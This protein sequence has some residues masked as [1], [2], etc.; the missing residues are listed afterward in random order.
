MLEK[1]RVEKDNN[2]KFHTFTVDAALLRELGERLV[3]KPYVALAELVK[4]S[5]DAD[6]TEVTVTFERDSITVSDNGTGMS[7]PEFIAYWLR[8]GTTHKQNQKLTKR[9]RQVTGSKGV[10]RLSV[11]F[12]GDELEI[13]S[14]GIAETSAFQASVNW[15][16]AREANDLVK[17][18]AYVSTTP[19][20]KK[21]DH[22]YEH[23][24]SVK[25]IGL[26]HQWLVEDLT[27]LAGELWFLKPPTE[28]MADDSDDIFDIQVKGL[29]A[30]A[31]TA[32]NSQMDRALENWIAIIEGKLNAGKSQGKNEVTVTFKNGDEY[33]AS[34]PPTTR[35]LDKVN[36]K[37]YVFKLSGKQAGG[38]NVNEARDYFRKFGG[39]HIY[40]NNFRL[41]F[42]GGNEQD[43]LELEIDHSH[44][45]NKSKLLPSNL[46]VRSGLN[47]L[48]TNGRI[49]GAVKISTSHERTTA[50]PL[51]LNK[52][53]YLNVQ[54]TRDRL[55]DNDAFEELQ[56]SVRWAIDFYAMRS[57][58]RRSI[59][60]A[61]ARLDVPKTE[62]T[63]S[64]IRNQLFQL[65][66]KVPDGLEAE[67]EAVSL[68]FKELEDLEEQRNSAINEERI[69]L[70]ALAT[71]GMAALAMEHELHK[72]LTVL[73]DMRK[74][75]TDKNKILDMPKLISSLD[76][77]AE[78]TAK[79]RKLFSPLMNEYD[80]EKRNKYNVSKVL[81][82]IVINSEALLRQV[83]VEY[84]FPKMMILPTATLAAWNAVFQNVL[85]N[86]V[87]AMID[88][89]KRL[90]FAYGETRGNYSSVIIAD[91]G[92][93]VRLSDSADLFKPFIRRLEIPEERKA[94]GLGGMGIG[95]TIVKMVA[96]SLDCS[97]SFVTPP[98]GF[99]TAFKLEW[100][101][102]E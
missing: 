89:N 5:Y 26:K 7:R 30:Q 2:R 25:I 69:L 86:A 40:D 60:K 92:V 71:S 41:P 57:F 36:F 73:S 77:W 80:R 79:A 100:N 48:P 95:L 101:H 52:G 56:Y 59:I 78:R 3:G 12:L 85:I 94:L 97:V 9:S 4:N 15:G 10:G 75:L 61:S 74:Q 8:V 11:Q 32:F 87:N 102:N 63:V 45:L 17:A 51:E 96:D 35:L 64:E 66:M 34:F 62:E 21:I 50:S 27:D 49:F 31:K 28:L 93:G 44:R 72:E 13:V 18:G 55:I 88:S 6:A 65:S 24:T 38:I 58:E 54:V 46:Q 76:N 90:I 37:I 84:S 1:K 20:T 53:A 70:A 81:N 14:K 82:R 83:N 39:I 67:V 68:K 42:Y 47:D 29:T 43:W 23:G 98:A 22:L 16:E 33:K 99:K 19:N 91:T